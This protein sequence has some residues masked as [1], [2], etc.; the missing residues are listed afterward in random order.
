MTTSKPGRN[1][2]SRPAACPL[3]SVPF[4][5][6][7]ING[8]FFRR[9]R[10]ICIPDLVAATQGGASYPMARKMSGHGDSIT[11]WATL[12]ARRESSAC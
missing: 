9:C 2:I 8:E 11:S 3:L 5:Q 6:A 1:S 7:W 10:S 12:Q 4:S